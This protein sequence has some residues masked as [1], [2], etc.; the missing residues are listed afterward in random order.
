MPCALYVPV[1][2]RMLFILTSR[3][4]TVSSVIKDKV[5]ELQEMYREDG[6]PLPPPTPTE[7]CSAIRI[8]WS[9]RTDTYT[10]PNSGSA[11][12]LVG[13]GMGGVRESFTLIEWVQVM[14]VLCRATSNSLNRSMGLDPY[15]PHSTPSDSHL[16]ANTISAKCHVTAMAII[17]SFL[18]T[19]VYQSTKFVILF[20][21]N[22]IS[23]GTYSSTIYSCSTNRLHLKGLHKV[24]QQWQ[25]LKKKKKKRKK[26]KKKKKKKMKKKK[27]RRRRK[28]WHI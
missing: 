18:K 20:A 22:F 14:Y 12:A 3:C 28:C 11:C 2:K 26:K 9:Y 15:N 21:T 27:K 25:N 8:G 24:C 1:S 19:F 13:D 10:V 17:I 23:I 5:L 7:I 6:Y 16:G 4:I